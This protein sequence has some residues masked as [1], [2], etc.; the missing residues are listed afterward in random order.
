MKEGL[1]VVLVLLSLVALTAI[2]VVSLNGIQVV[3]KDKEAVT[4]SELQ[5]ILEP[6]VDKLNQTGERVVA[7]ENR[8]D[9]K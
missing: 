5:S 8:K 4:R 3:I 1:D 7:M 2:T 6:L 9:K